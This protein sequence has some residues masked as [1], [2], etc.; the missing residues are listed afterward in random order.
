MVSFS[1]LLKSTL[2]PRIARYTTCDLPTI[3]NALILSLL[4]NETCML[5]NL[6]S[7]VT[8]VCTGCNKVGC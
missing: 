2:L 6:A 1:N 5:T 7:T 3:W 4:Y 8:L